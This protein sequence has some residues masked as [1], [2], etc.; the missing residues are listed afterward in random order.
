MFD[1]DDVNEGKDRL[2]K[3][4]DNGPKS[5]SRFSAF[6]WRR[7]DDLPPQDIKTDHVFLIFL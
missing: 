7:G 2:M 4:D 3:N 1:K 5:Q 6:M